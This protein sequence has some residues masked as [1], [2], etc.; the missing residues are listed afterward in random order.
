V[1]VEQ[2][3]QWKSKL[4]FIL[5]ASGSAIGLGNIVFFS[6]NAYRFGGGAFYLPYLIALFLIGIPVMNLE[7]GLGHHTGVAFPQSMKKA[8]GTTGE[9]IGWWAIFNAS[10]ITMYYITILAWVLGMLVGS[11]GALWKESL[12]LPAFGLAD[13]DLGNPYAYFFSMLSS[14][15]PVIYVIIVWIMNA[16]I[17]RRGAA[18]I[19]PAVRVFVPLMWVFMIVLIVRGLTL[20]SGGQGVMLLFTPDFS[21]MKNPEVWQG[22][23]SQIFFT[24]SLGFGIMTAY[25]SYLPKKSDMVNNAFATSFLNCGFEYIAGLAIFSILFAFAMIPK[26]STLSM[27]FFVVPQGISQ[28]PGG[29][30]SVMSFGILFFVL[31]MLAGLSSS[32]SLVEA[33]VAS[34]VDKF[35]SGRA[36][37]ITIFC[38]I[39]V[40]GSVAFSLPQV[41]NPGLEDDGTLGFTLLDLFDHWAF[42]HGLLIVGLLECVLI[43][44]IYGVRKVRDSINAESSYHL[45]Y[46]YEILIKYVIPALILF[47]LISSAY[48]EVTGGLYGT[49][50]TPNFSE[51]WTSLRILPAVVVVLWIS[52]S[53]LAAFFLTRSKGKES[54][55]E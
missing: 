39:G 10:Y 3:S 34:V 6:A 18:T 42:S 19:E 40:L 14:W 35:G 28:L 55:G 9:F 13:G 48:D 50:F 53:A 21:V 52:L 36:K 5:A 23:F 25:A 29:A 24:L 15:K 8:A 31:L 49:E 22:A 7:F 38:I 2:R 37:T 51:E 17:V 16:L 44:W 41:V 33:L 12:P 46:F 45:G 26:A 32:V 47:V 11:F 4:G 54:A 20:P 43:G 1:A 27:M 30:A